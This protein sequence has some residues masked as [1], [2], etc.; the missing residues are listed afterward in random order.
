MQI[1]RETLKIVLFEKVHPAAEQCFNEAGLQVTVVPDAPSDEQLSEYI[2]DAHVIGLRSRT[3]IRE[4]HLRAAKN[5]LAIGCFSV[6]VDAVDIDVARSNGVAVFNAPHSSTRSVAELALGNIIGLA[7]RSFE[8]SAKLHNGVWDKSLAEAIEIRDK[9]VGL[10]GYGHIGQQVGL[11][12]EAIGMNVV[13]YDTLKKLP[14]GRAR[15]VSSLK[16]LLQ[17]A[18]FVSLHVPGGV[19]TRMMMGKSQLAVM[20][21]G[22]FL[23][24]LSRGTVLDVEALVSALNS[25]HLA[26]AAIDVYPDEPAKVVSEFA[27]PLIGLE[28]VILT[29]HIGGSTEEAQR[30]IGREV[31]KA[32][33]SYIDFGSTQGAVNFPQVHLAPF[34]SAQ[35]ILNIHQNLPGALSELN[36]VISDSGANIDA[37]HLSTYSDVGYL[38]VDFR[39]GVS[40]SMIKRIEDLPK[41]IRTRLLSSVPNDEE[42]HRDTSQA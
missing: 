16:D 10:V 2:A 14:L 40:N 23:I 32:I 27:S 22:S 35:R 9:V 42:S 8:K 3:K 34:P 41:S 11:L 20:K 36:A 28:N 31:A 4:H 29:P 38:I 19:E 12:A 21:K 26:G 18:D 1:K 15:P 6:G 39:G 33:I 24:N 13:F 37:Q 30:N 17:V 25:K 7:R 5:L